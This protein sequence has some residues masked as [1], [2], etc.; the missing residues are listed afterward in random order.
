MPD[1]FTLNEV[2]GFHMEQI[3]LYGGSHGVRD[4]RLLESALAMP[5]SGLGDDYFHEFP[6]GMAAAYLF[7]IVQNHPFIDGNKRTG[8]ATCLYFLGLHDVEIEVDPDELE[9]FVRNVATGKL[10]KTE[11]ADFLRQHWRMSEEQG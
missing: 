5:M 11:I 10:Q 9:K 3:E 4:L 8:L 6:F 7:H 2:L 1:F